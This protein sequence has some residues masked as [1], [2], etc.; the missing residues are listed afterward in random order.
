MSADP[1]LA[2]LTLPR[3]A[4]LQGEVDPLDFVLTE[5]A[6]RV[7]PAVRW[8]WGVRRHHN[9]AVAR[10]YL[11]ER[12]LVGWA[13][14]WPMTRSAVESVLVHRTAELGLLRALTGSDTAGT[15]PVVERTAGGQ[16]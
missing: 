3:A 9:Q 13:S 15:S 7:H 6:R 16:S 1:R 12:D 10:C 4:I 11:C 2:A 5:H 8:W 14:A